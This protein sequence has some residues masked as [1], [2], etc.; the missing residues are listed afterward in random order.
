M[1]PT[2]KFETTLHNEETIANAREEKKEDEALDVLDV[3]GLRAE[4]EKMKVRR[5]SIVLHPDTGEEMIR[6]SKV[7]RVQRSINTNYDTFLEL[8]SKATFENSVSMWLVIFSSRHPFLRKIRSDV[9]TEGIPPDQRTKERKERIKN[10]LRD[11][12]MPIEAWLA[13]LDEYKNKLVKFNEQLEARTPHI[14]KYIAKEFIARINPDLENPKTEEELM[15]VLNSVNLRIK[16][17]LNSYKSIGSHS[18]ADSTI[19]LNLSILRY[20]L[21]QDQDFSPQALDLIAHEEMH[22]LSSGQV[23]EHKLTFTYDEED[24]E[25][26]IDEDMK[27]RGVLQSQWHGLL[28]SGFEVNRFSWLNEAITETLSAKLVGIDPIHYPKEREFLDL[29]LIKGKK[30]IDK[31]LLVNAYFEKRGYQA[32]DDEDEKHKF[33]KQFRQ[34][35]REAYDHDPQFLVKLD[36]LIQEKGVD[37]AITLLKEWNTENPQ[38]TTAMSAEE[39]VKI[40]K[41]KE[42]EDALA[43]LNE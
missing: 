24:G 1:N 33:W 22:A 28:V 30:P 20:D 3:D 5:Q 38:K 26:E 4:I 17:P 25:E 8:E 40:R 13:A 35:V 29:F 36:I 31:K 34:E 39:E 7:D 14:R 18:S 6:R 10:A 12:S 16:D 41:E 11:R 19:D 32:P 9:E 37:A 15:H 27:T 42:I 43:A 23:V 2:R 21:A